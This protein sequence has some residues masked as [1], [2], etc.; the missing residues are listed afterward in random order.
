L[1]NGIPKTAALL[2]ESIPRRCRTVVLGDPP[3]HLR[4][5]GTAGA[6]TD[7]EGPDRQ[8]RL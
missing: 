4:Q 3:P 8:R 6:R 7:F 1:S 5:R 2:K